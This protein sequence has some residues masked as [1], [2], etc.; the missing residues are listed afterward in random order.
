MAAQQER[1]VQIMPAEPGWRWLQIAYP[2]ADQPI[3]PLAFIEDAVIGWAL[4]EDD[5]GFQWITG[6]A[7]LE[8]GTVGAIADGYTSHVAYLAPG[9]TITQEMKDEA[10]SMVIADRQFREKNGR[11]R[12]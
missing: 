8:C 12:Q 4:M 7:P 3:E 6:I 9:Q 2:L 5:R 1:I 10:R 11:G